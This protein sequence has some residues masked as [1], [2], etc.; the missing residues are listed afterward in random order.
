MSG[1]PVESTPAGNTRLRAAGRRARTELS[2]SFESDRLNAT[3]V[4]RAGLDTASYAQLRHPE[5]EPPRRASLSR[6]ADARLLMTHSANSQSSAGPSVL[7]SDQML[8]ALLEQLDL[9]ESFVPARD[10]I[11]VAESRSR[12]TRVAAQSF[13]LAAVT[14][15]LHRLERNSCD[16]GDCYT[17]TSQSSSSA[18]LRI[19]IVSSMPPPSTVFS[20]PMPQPLSEPLPT[21]SSSPLLLFALSPLSLSALT[22]QPS[23]PPLTLSLTAPMLTV[24]VAAAHDSRSPAMS[25]LLRNQSSPH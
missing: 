23:L 2:S 25:F 7:Y 8:A 19:S 1:E 6:S 15:R 18:P 17:P 5:C 3:V 16:R 13:A 22:P 20:N 21:F 11:D 9:L 12:A 10:A 14:D 4:Q 24:A